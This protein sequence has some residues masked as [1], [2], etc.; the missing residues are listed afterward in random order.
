MPASFLANRLTGA[1]VL[2][3][4]SSSQ[5]VP[6]YDATALDWY[7]PWAKLVQ[8]KMKPQMDTDERGS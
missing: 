3:H 4:H 5:S 1:Y 6:L 7:A 2:D 8:E